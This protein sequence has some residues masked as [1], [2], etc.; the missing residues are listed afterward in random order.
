[1]MH[2]IVLGV[3][4]VASFFGAVLCSVLSL[5]AC[6]CWCAVLCQGCRP[7][8][9][10]LW[11]VLRFLLACAA[12]HIKA[13]LCCAMLC[14]VLRLFACL[15]CALCCALCWEMLATAV[16]RR[17]QAGM[18]RSLVCAK[19]CT[20][21][22]VQGWCREGTACLAKKELPYGCAKRGVSTQL[23]GMPCC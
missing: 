2:T 14:A 23:C 17:L 16:V 22:V 21:H 6:L 7:S 19:V 5:F 11:A 10:V 4:N 1:M 18:K 15:C 8:C 3:T 9:A 13:L 12:P 20:T